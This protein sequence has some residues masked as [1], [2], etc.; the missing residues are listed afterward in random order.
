MPE[1]RLDF[2]LNETI[3][4]SV[5]KNGKKTDVL[6]KCKIYINGSQSSTQP[7]TQ[8]WEYVV[9]PGNPQEATIVTEVSTFNNKHQR[10][11]LYQQH[12]RNTKPVAG[13]ELLQRWGK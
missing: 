3:P 1:H 7:C 8:G 10:F 12:A 9:Y 11:P 5:D 13:R 2:P 4:L 6:E